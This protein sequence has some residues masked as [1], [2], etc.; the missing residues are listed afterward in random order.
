MPTAIICHNDLMAIGVQNA[1]NE[2]GIKSPRNLSIIGY[3]NIEFSKYSFPSLTTIKIP[4]DEIAY[5]AVDG[6][7]LKYNKSAGKIIITVNPSLVVRNSVDE[8]NEI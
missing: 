3:D 5:Q 4:L 1:A 6:L 7:K 2:L 8:P